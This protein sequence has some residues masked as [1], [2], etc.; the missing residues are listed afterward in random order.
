MWNRLFRSPSWVKIAIFSSVSSVLSP[1]LFLIVYY[2][3]IPSR[4]MPRISRI[5]TLQ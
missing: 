4:T 3:Q 5:Q 1:S 2:V